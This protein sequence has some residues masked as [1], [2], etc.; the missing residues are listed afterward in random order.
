MSLPALATLEELSE[1]LGVALL[2]EHGEPRSPDGVRAQAALDDASAL[3]RQEAGRNWV[4]EDHE[5]LEGVP[6]VVAAICLAAASRAMR[7]PEGA[8]QASVGDA[9]I[10]YHR[11][12]GGAAVY[13]TD[14]EIRAV[15]KAAGRASASSVEVVSPWGAAT[16]AA[17][18]VAVEGGEPMLFGPLPGD[19]P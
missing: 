12:G 14:A 2:D 11:A 8:T 17:Y 15:R 3:I 5:A 13:L 10:S 7:N 16:P 1:R 4:D 9:S 19:L 6:D 18:M